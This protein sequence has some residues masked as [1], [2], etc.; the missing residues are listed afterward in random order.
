MKY[1][2]FI[3]LSQYYTN[4]LMDSSEYFQHFISF[5][6]SSPPYLLIHQR[7]SPYS[8][9]STPTT[10]SEFHQTN[11]QIC[12]LNKMR[13]CK[14]HISTT[15]NSVP[16]PSLLMCQPWLS[17]GTS[18]PET[19][20][21]QYYCRTALHFKHWHSFCFPQGHP[22]PLHSTNSCIYQRLTVTNHHCSCL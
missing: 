10:L 16:K 20:P 21:A 5:P 9:Q 12:V 19:E 8:S 14:M 6:C 13:Q 22:L 15:A 7:L 4:L 1:S 11:S 17:L 2:Q 3:W 18:I